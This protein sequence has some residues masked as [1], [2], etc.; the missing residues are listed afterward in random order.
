[1]VE[2]EFE[3]DSPIANLLKPEEKKQDEKPRNPNLQWDYDTEIVDMDEGW[4]YELLPRNGKRSER[5][6][7]KLR[8]FCQKLYRGAY[9]DEDVPSFWKPRLKDIAACEAKRWKAH[10]YYNNQIKK[11]TSAFDLVLKNVPFCCLRKKH[12]NPGKEN[13]WPGFSWV[14]FPK[15]NSSDPGV[16]WSW[17]AQQRNGSNLEHPDCPV[18]QDVGDAW[19]DYEI[20]SQQL[21]TR[22]SYFE[23]L[24]FQSIEQRYSSEFYS[25]RYVPY[26]RNLVINGRNYLIGLQDGR[27]FGI[28][29]YPENIITTVI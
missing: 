22:K 9:R 29:A 5:K 25:A 27:K 8:K 3:F 19:F 1:M 12:Y 28:I 15:S 21:R 18:K 26:M 23:S 24:F 2:E 13:E 20:R 10:L 16:S 14:E 11:V 7:K 17:W 4:I 6:G